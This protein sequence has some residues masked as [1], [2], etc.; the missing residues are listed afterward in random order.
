MVLEGAGTMVV[1]VNNNTISGNDP[2]GFDF[3]IRGGARAG[4]GTANFQVNNNTA[5]GEGAGAWFFAGNASAGETSRT[6]VNFVGNNI[7][8]G[9]TS[10]A[11][12]FVEMYTNTTFQLQ[13]FTGV[14]TS[15]AAVAAFIA[16][17]DDDAGSLVDAGSGTTVNYTSATCST[18]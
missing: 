2:T 1:D 10:F 17:R 5:F 3:G 8:G 14:G 9:T 7:D 6:C 4:S 11:D 12:Y 16:S 18:P 13:G 15:A